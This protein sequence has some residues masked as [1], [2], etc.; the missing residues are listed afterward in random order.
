MAVSA[1]DK[2]VRGGDLTTIG[3][4]VKTA[5]NSVKVTV[6][7]DLTTGGSSS[8]LSAEQGKVIKASLDN[9]LY[10]GET[11]ATIPD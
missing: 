4:A 6:V 5:I 3:A 10:L 2:V 11:I 8:A 7:D 1:E 9:A